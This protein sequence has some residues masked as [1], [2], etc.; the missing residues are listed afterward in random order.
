MVHIQRQG[1]IRESREACKGVHG[2][3]V[4]VIGTKGQGLGYYCAFENTLSLS[5]TSGK[6]VRIKKNMSRIHSF[7]QVDISLEFSQHNVC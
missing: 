2:V 5:S 1:W 4:S 6:E 3:Y 7:I